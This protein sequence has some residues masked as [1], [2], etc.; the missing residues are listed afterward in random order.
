MNQTVRLKKAGGAVGPR[1]VVG[2]PVCNEHA[3]IEACVKSLANQLGCAADDYGILLF[4][5]NCSDGT[6]ELVR[7]LIPQIACAIRVVEQDN[8][9]ASAGWARRCAMDAASAWLAESGHPDGV[10]LTTDAD[11]RVGSDWLARNLR[12]IE[13]GLDAVAGR[14]SL[15]C[16]EAAMLPAP[17]HARGRLEAAYEALLTEISARL[18]PQPSDPWPC[19]WT[20]SGASLAVR[21]SAYLAVGGMP[22]LPLGEDHAFVDALLRSDMLVRHAPEIVVITSGRL[23]GRAAGGAADTMKLRCQLLDSACDDR[24]ERLD[25]ALIRYCW[26]RTLRRA[27]LDGRLRYGRIWAAFLGLSMN[28]LS[29]LVR[30]QTLGQ[31]QCAIESASPRLAYHALL[32]AQLSRQIGFARTVFAMLQRLSHT[33]ALDQAGGDQ[34]GKA[35]IQASE[36]TLQ[37]TRTP[38]LQAGA[39]P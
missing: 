22:D 25:R 3:R 6:A 16:E 36:S 1:A 37:L 14:F 39:S 31:A 20:R 17:L 12:Y 13:A 19:H 30:L 10:L 18:D 2:V 27:H 35:F 34:F 7:S 38:Q 8:P 28:K 24:L 29:V 33:H 9:S 11:T 4:L 5:N 15:D 23:D 26:R 21:R 32:P